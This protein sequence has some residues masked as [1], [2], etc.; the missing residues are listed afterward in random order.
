MLSIAAAM[1]AQS[2]KAS[3]VDLNLGCPQDRAREDLFGSY[4][5]DKCHWP[6]VFRCVEAMAAALKE[7]DV[8]LFC[9]IRL[10]E[11]VDS[12]ELTKEFCR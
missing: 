2:R 7:Y 4:L 11:G 8:P 9:K 12:V 6:L 5:L 1:I 3:A 10:I